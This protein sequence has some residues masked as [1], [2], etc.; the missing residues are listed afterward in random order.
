MVVHSITK[1][2][3]FYASVQYREKLAWHELFAINLAQY[4]RW[5]AYVYDHYNPVK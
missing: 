3:S 2:Y 5:D 1:Q 4:I